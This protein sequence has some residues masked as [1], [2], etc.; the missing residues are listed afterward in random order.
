MS[1]FCVVYPSLLKQS[2]YIHR[3]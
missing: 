1:I 2:I 3:I